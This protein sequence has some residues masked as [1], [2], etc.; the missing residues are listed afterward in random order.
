MLRL[1]AA[2]AAL[3][4]CVA[5]AYAATEDRL[6]A[7]FTHDEQVAGVLHAGTWWLM[8]GMAA[9]FPTTIVLTGLIFAAQMFAYMRTLQL[10]GFAGIFCPALWAATHLARGPGGGGGGCAGGGASLA[11]IWAAKL[12]FYAWQLLAEGAGV[13]GTW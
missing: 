12:A 4:T 5:A 8:C 9:F 6:V 3:G 1:L 11:A 13:A 10:A 2:C 7:L